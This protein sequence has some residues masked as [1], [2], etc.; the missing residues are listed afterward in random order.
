ME[1]NKKIHIEKQ[2]PEWVRQYGQEKEQLCR[3]LSDTVSSISS[4]KLLCIIG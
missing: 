1:N 3:A 4:Y 2:N